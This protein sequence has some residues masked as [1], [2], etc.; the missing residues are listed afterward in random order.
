MGPPQS[1]VLHTSIGQI[2]FASQEC[3]V[4]GHL[5]P[6][7]A[8]RLSLLAGA[9]LCKEGLHDSRDPALEN[10]AGFRSVAPSATGSVACATLAC[11]HPVPGMLTFGSHTVTIFEHSHTIIAVAI[12][13]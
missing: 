7:P 6:E 12:I 5:N 4:F 8:S 3:T 9:Q 10:S 1:E 11:V 13:S 2:T